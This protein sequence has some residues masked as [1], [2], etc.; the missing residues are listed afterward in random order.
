MEVRDAEPMDIVKRVRDRRI[1]FLLFNNTSKYVSAATGC[2]ICCAMLVQMIMSH[3]YFLLDLIG[4]YATIN[5]I[6]SMTHNK[7]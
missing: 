7:F 5:Y 2:T 4:L 1:V 3:S 6:N